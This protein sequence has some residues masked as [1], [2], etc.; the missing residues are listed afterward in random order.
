MKWINNVFR[1]LSKGYQRYV[2][3]TKRIDKVV[4]VKS[5]IKSSLGSL[6]I[7]LLIILIPVLIIINMFIYAKLTLFLAILLVVMI[8]GAVFLYFHFYYVL[9]KNYHE[10]LAEISYKQPQLIESTVV[11]IIIVLLGIVVISVVL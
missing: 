11:A 10:K 8:A 7:T 5:M 3:L 6:L 9:L 1:K 4:H 2:V